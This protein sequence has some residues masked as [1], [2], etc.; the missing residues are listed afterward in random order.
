MPV[1]FLAVAIGVYVALDDKQ[2][3]GLIGMVGLAIWVPVLL[4][5]IGARIQPRDRTRAG[6]IDFGNRR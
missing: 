2:L 6:S 4:G 1:V 3:A 5:L